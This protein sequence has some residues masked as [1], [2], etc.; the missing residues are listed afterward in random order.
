MP[1]VL[2]TLAACSGLPDRVDT[3]EQARESIAAVA[4]EPLAGQVAT[5]ELTEARAALTAADA[6]FEQGE[7]LPL[8]EHHAY[9]AQRYA[10]ISRQLV[11]E[12]QAR[13]E[14]R[15]RSGA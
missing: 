4:R 5:Q 15:R 3:V 9:V 7:P 13:E 11:A 10:D 1:L 6:A 14:V 12:A 8:I 2:L